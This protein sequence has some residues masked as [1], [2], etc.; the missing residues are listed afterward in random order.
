LIG[1]ETF[2][3][4]ERTDSPVWA[5]DEVDSEAVSEELSHLVWVEWEVWDEADSYLDSEVDSR[6]VSEAVSEGV[7]VDSVDLTADLAITVVQLPWPVVETLATTST[8]T[9][10]VPKVPQLALLPEAPP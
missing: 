9:T 8:P 1:S 7:E 2:L 5:V 4:F 10:A 3:K 6:L